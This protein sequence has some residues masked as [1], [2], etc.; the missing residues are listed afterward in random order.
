MIRIKK[1]EEIPLEIPHFN[2]DDNAV[3][4][5]LNDHPLTQLMNVYGFLCVIGRPGSGKTSLTISLMTQKKPKIYRK[6]HHHMI[7]L[8]PHNSIGSLKNNPFK[9]LPEEN[10]YGELTESNMKE[11]YERIDSYSQENEKTLLFID[12]MTADLKKSKYIENILKRIIYNRRHLKCNV[13][14]TAQSYSNIPLDIRKNITNCILFKPAKKEIEILFEELV[15]S[16]KDTFNDVMRITFDQKHNFL[17]VNIP[18]Q[19]MFR[20]WDELIFKSDNDDLNS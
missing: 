10:I 14:I 20:N 16:K 5:H 19:R 8:M 13:I 18:S 9:V 1:N 15:E 7:I 4:D 17:F 6:T 2:C 3:G 12:D 11:I